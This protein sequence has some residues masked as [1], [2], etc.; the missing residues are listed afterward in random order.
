[1]P[2]LS[3]STAEQ[4]TLWRAW[5]FHES[6]DKNSR[7]PSAGFPEALV[8]AGLLTLSPMQPLCCAD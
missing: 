2:G 5:T 4:A 3:C 8:R 1:M 7:F 6:W